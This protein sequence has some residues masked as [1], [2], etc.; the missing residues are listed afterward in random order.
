[1]L[2]GQSDEARRQL[3]ISSSWRYGKHTDAQSLEMKLIHAYCAFLDY[4]IW[5][6]KTSTT[7]E[8]GQ[9]MYFMW[10]YSVLVLLQCTHQ[11]TQT[12][13]YG[14]YVLSYWCRE[15]QISMSYISIRK[16][17][18]VHLSVLV[19]FQRMTEV[20]KRSISDKLQWPCRRLY[21]IRESGTLLC[22]VTLLWDVIFDFFKEVFYI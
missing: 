8:T 19:L 18:S 13:S 5:S 7:P 16:Q 3:S 11:L 21:T 17:S 20:Q 14:G 12:I 2:N 22:W 4:F 1:M 6:K 9:F 10:L 15:S